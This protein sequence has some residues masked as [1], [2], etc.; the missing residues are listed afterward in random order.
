MNYALVARNLRVD[1][2]VSSIVEAMNQLGRSQCVVSNGAPAFIKSKLIA[3]RMDGPLPWVLTPDSRTRPKPAPDLYMSATRVFALDPSLCV[4]VE[5]SALG[6]RA[7]VS[8]GLDV[9]HVSFQ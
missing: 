9:I 6:V 1:V 2:E 8:A 5:D 7:A 4:A 3:S